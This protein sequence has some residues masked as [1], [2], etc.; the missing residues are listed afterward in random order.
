[1]PVPIFADGQYLGTVQ[2]GDS[3]G[4]FKFRVSNK[5]ALLTVD[6]EMTILTATSQ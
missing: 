6:P 3:E 1:M 4:Q 5:P 2:V